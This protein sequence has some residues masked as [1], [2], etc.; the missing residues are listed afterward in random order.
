MGLDGDRRVGK[1]KT[2]MSKRIEDPLVA[3][4][5]YELMPGRYVRWDEVSRLVQNLDRVHDLVNAV[6]TANGLK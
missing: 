6:K 5:R 2:K 4:F 1:T 3:E